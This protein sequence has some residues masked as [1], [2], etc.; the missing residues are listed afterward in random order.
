MLYSLP[1]V[2]NVLSLLLLIFFIYAILGVFLFYRVT[3]GKAVDSEYTNFKNFGLA[4]ITLLRVATG[5]EWNVVMYD[6]IDETPAA[7]V[8][9][10]SFVTIT[11]FVMLN[12]FIMVIL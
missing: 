9:F 4:M 11:T 2:L 8:Y 10:L 6:Y 1:S 5:E 7:I 12:M 3:D